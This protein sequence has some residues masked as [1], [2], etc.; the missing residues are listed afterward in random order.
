MPLT[1]DLRIK[2]TPVQ[3]ALIKN[4]AQAEGYKTMSA[5]IRKR[6]VKEED[7]IERMIKEIYEMV[8]DLLEK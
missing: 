5:F 4:K 8:Q 6:I 7:D 1:R 3:Y 2:V